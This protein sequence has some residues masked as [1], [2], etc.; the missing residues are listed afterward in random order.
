[1]AKGRITSCRA[2]DN[3]SRPGIVFCK[4]C[5]ELFHSLVDGF[6]ITGRQALDLMEMYRADV[7]AIHEH[8]NARIAPNPKPK[9]EITIDDIPDDFQVN[10]RIPKHGWR[11]EHRIALQENFMVMAFITNDRKW[12][13]QIAKVKENILKEY[14]E[15]GANEL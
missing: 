4:E 6:N 13:K 5:E 11:L 3:A 7:E 2:C 10:H 8:I 12:A 1:M 14:A 9:K 15:E